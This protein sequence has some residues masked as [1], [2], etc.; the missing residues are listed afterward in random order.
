MPRLYVAQFSAVAVTAAQDFFEILCATDGIIR[1]H[2]WHLFQ[3]TDVADAAEEV[4]RIE[5]VRGI[6]A[7]TGSGGS[8]ATPQPLDD[9]DA[10]S[11]ATVE[12]N[13]TT[14]L[15]AG[16][17]SLEVLEAFGWN[18]RIP[19]SEI[20]TPELRPVVGPGEFWT[21]SL[22][23]APTDSITASGSVWFEEVGG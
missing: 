12:I 6:G 13:N 20:Y 4:L 3:T 1:I 16:G 11:G 22:V 2:K 14:R 5:T 10:A 9:G 8:T 23:A 21:L 17:G 7:T 15:T 18:I 19:T